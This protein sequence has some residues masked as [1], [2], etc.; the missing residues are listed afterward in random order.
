MP[1]V[2]IPDEITGTFEGNDSA[3][4]P[5]VYTGCIPGRV[6]YGTRDVTY[7]QRLSQTHV[8]FYSNGFKVTSTNSNSGTVAYYVT[9]TH[10]GGEYDGAKIPFN[11]PASGVYN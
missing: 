4:G 5:F 8:E 1:L 2:D 3:D 11:L 10:T 9:T 7:D 6:R